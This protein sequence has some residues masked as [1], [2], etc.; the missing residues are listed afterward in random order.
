MRRLGGPRARQN[1]EI[2]IG[3]ST[4]LPPDHLP[5][6]PF[7]PVS[8]DRGSDLLRHGKPPARSPQGVGDRKK[9]QPAAGHPFPLLLAFREIAPFPEPR[10]FRETRRRPPGR[11]FPERH[12]SDRQAFAPFAAAGGKD[13]AA[14]FRAHPGAKTVGFLAPTVVGLIGPLHGSSVPFAV[15]TL[16]LWREKT[17]VKDSRSPMPSRSL[18]FAV[19]GTRISRRAF[20]SCGKPCGKK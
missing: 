13:G 2:P 18:L 5:E 15:K 7:H 19:G 20:H 14:G 9:N 4:L 16:I 1:A 12:A 8:E 6:T 3:P 11:R 10:G 17:Q